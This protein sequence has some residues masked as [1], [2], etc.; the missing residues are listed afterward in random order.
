VRDFLTLHRLALGLDIVDAADAV[1][2]VAA[3]NSRNRRA[4]V[5]PASG[6][7]RGATMPSRV[8]AARALSD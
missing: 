1:L 3:K 5:S 2:M 6:I 8:V 7:T 4:A